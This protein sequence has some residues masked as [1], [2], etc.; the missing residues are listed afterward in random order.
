MVILAYG[1]SLSQEK[2]EKK[3]LFSSPAQ[4]DHRLN[5]AYFQWYLHDTKELIIA[6]GRWK[7][8]DWLIFGGASATAASDSKN[9]RDSYPHTSPN[10]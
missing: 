7:G 9:P 8:K 6:P 1:N 5:G 4:F 3:G 2:K 10:F